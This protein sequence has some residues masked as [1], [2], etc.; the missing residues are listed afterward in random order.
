M[1]STSATATPARSAIA[2]PSPVETGGL[3]V[4]AKHWP[5]PPVA[6]TVWRAR[7]WRGA[8]GGVE[9]AHAD[10]AAALHEQVG[11]QPPLADLDV[12]VEGGRGERA[13]DLGAGGVAAGVDDPGARSGRPH[14]WWPARR[15]G[16][17]SAR[18]SAISS[19]TRSGPSVTSTR[20]ASASQ[21]AHPR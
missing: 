21:R 2:M 11:H 10:G 15:R 13:L 16:D 5:A 9:R 18:R 3:V 7:T 6:R 17:R 1:N 4:T 8:P 12:E 19:R 20:T 14:G